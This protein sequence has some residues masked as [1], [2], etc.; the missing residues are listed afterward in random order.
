[1]NREQVFP[2]IYEFIVESGPEGAVDISED[3]S[4]FEN[5][6]LDSFGIV[7]LVVFLEDTF[8][9]HLN[10]DDLS[11]EN[12]ASVAAITNTVVLKLSREAE[13]I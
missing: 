3:E 5:G 6:F 8:D 2:L 1:M 10:D 12:L 11:E 4:L 13:A 9:I 7:S